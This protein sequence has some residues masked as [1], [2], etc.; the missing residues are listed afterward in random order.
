MAISRVER[1]FDLTLALSS[2]EREI[3]NLNPEAK[4]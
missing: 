1:E 2:V 4:I 3:E